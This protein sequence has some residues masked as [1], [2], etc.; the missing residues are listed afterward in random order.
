VVGVSFRRASDAPSGLASEFVADPRPVDG[1]ECERPFCESTAAYAVPHE[2]GFGGDRAVCEYHLAVYADEHPGTWETLSHLS[3]SPEACADAGA[4]V[5]SWDA[6]PPSR[7]VGDVVV[8]RVAL[9]HLG[10][11]IFEDPP[12]GDGAGTVTY[13]L[14]TRSEVVDTC[15]LPTDSEAWGEF[16]SWVRRERGLRRVDGSWARAIPAAWGVAGAAGGGSP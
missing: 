5:V 10:G 9:D 13:Y 14:T 7:Q 3:P 4:R 2:G 12:A 16:L 1:G 15:S 8:S 6:V 11:A